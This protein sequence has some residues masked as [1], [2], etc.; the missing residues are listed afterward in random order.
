MSIYADLVVPALETIARPRM[1]LLEVGGGV[2]AVLQRNLSMLDRLEVDYKFTDL[3]QSFVQAARHGYSGRGRL[4]FA[5][6]DLDSP[7]HDQGLLPESFDVV[8]AVN[9]L[10]VVKHLSLS[11]R[12]LF[13][14]LRPRGY[15]L[16]SEGS[17]PDRF[18]RWR[19]DIIF[20]FL[21]GWW[22]VS[23]GAPWRPRPGF[24]L[25]SEW[26]E[27]LLECCYD[28]VH[29]LPGENWFRQACRGGLILAQKQ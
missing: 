4:T 29:L 22:N 21:R 14:V 20:G 19:P 13:D 7:F 5:R 6:L 26:K 17:P 18:R 3:G 23:T 24:L 8:I 15:L 9:V 1:Q 11:L 10:H 28:P 25:P 12:E 2:G 16:L 27:A